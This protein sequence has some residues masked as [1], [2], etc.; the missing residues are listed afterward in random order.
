MAELALGVARLA[1]LLGLADA[2]DR[3]AARRRARPAPSAASARSVSPNSSRRSEWPRITPWTPTS[4]SI[5]AE[6][7]P[8]NAP[9]SAVVHVLG[10]DL[11]ARAAG[12][13]D[14]RARARGTAGRSP[15]S[16][17]STDETRGSSACD[18]LLGLGDRLVHLPV[19]GDERCAPGPD[20]AHVSAS[21]PGSCLALDQLERRAAA[22]RQVR[23]LVGEAE[24]LER[25]GRVAAADDG[26]PGRVRDRLGDRPRAGGERLEL[27][28]AH[29]PVPEHGPGRAR[30]LAPYAARGARADVEAHPAVGHVDAVDRLGRRR[31][32]PVARRSP[33][34]RAARARRARSALDASVCRASSTSSAAHSE[35]PTEWPCAAR[36]GKHIAPPIRIVS[37]T[38]RKRSITAILSLT[39]AP[40]RTATSGRAGSSSTLR[41]RRHLALEQQPGGVLGRPAARRPRSRR[42]RDGRRRTR[43]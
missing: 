11:D 6:T 40:P 18:E 7:S 19:A 31:R 24:L 21:T 5:G 25:R 38:S 36:N 3:D 1:L 2:Q 20:G 29:R 9:S 4:V 22:G 10:V 35:S 34:R 26:R 43:R 37:A 42:A 32:R 23:D 30:S 28:R 13:V 16:T 27:E 14:H 8:V 12:R 33:G 15:T 41:Q 17:P 39:L